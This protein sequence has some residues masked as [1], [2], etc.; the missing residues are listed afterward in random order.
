MRYIVGCF[1]GNVENTLG[2]IYPEQYNAVG[3]LAGSVLKGGPDP[4]TGSIDKG[5]LKG[6]RPATKQDFVTFRVQPPRDLF[7]ESL[8]STQNNS[9]TEARIRKAAKQQLHLSDQQIQTAFEHGHWWV[10]DKRT[11]ASWDAVDTDN[12]FDFEEIDGGDEDY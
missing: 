4:L 11:G 9:A 2:Y 6:I 3:I 10:I 1:N 7:E 8:P 5:Q 12:G